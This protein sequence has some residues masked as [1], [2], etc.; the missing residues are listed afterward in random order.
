MSKG[1]R[2]DKQLAN[3]P[4]EMV[5]LVKKAGISLEKKGMY[6]HRARVAL[7]LD[8]SG[9]MSGLYRS[10]KIQQLCERILALAVQLDDDGQVDVFLFGS[11]AHDVGPLD[12]NSRAGYVD[13]MLRRHRLEGGT[14]Y[15]KAMRMIRQHYFPD[16]GAGRRSAPRPD[17]LPIYVMF[18]TDGQTMDP[19]EARNQVA[20]S[21]YEPMFWQFMAIGQSSRNVE[22]AGAAPPPQ[23]KQR[24]MGGFLSRLIQ[25]DFGFLEELDD[26]GGRFIDNADFFSVADPMLLPDDQLYDLLMTEYPGWVRMARECGLLPTV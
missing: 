5:N 8:I 25:T 15:G 18:V 2:L 21:S 23:K 6:E 12:L 1:V 3:Q 4:P 16:S 7:C 17:K 9:S 13:N 11:D 14:N 26:M 22:V 19:N 24:G 20:W 10:G